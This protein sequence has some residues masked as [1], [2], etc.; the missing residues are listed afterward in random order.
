LRRAPPESKDDQ[1]KD[2]RH[3]ETCRSGFLIGLTRDT[4]TPVSQLYTGPF[5][6][7]GAL[8]QVVIRLTDYLCGTT[9]WP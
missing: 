6:F 9:M 8:D 5:P 3:E 2:E 4:G 7:R 1:S